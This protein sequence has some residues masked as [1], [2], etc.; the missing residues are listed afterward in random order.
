MSTELLPG[1]EPSAILLSIRPVFATLIESGAKTVELR[2]R[3]P[4]LPV[5]SQLVLYTTQ[6]VAAV[7]G[8]ARLRGT[9]SATLPTLWRRFGVAS[10]VSKATFDLYFDEC[11]H[12]FALEL[13]DFRPLTPTLSVIELRRIW[14]GFA[15]PQSYR[16]VPDHVLA[17]IRAR[18]ASPA[19]PS[20]TTA[21]QRSRR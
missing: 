7:A 4:E 14:P 11:A 19:K 3:F 15:P 6:P 18:T 2:R 8:L 10:A 9:T 13:E 20:S 12:G 21:H 17:K 1:F 16:Y 5:G